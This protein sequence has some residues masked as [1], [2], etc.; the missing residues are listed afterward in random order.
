VSNLNPLHERAR[1][2]WSDDKGTKPLECY[3]KYDEFFRSR[4]PGFTPTSILEI[5]VHLG[6]STKIFAEVYREAK[7]VGIDIEKHEIDFSHHSN[8]LYLQ[9]DQGDARTLLSIIVEHFPQGVDLVIDDASH[10]GCLSKMT[11]DAVF[12][13]VRPGGIYIVEDWGTGYWDEWVDG[14]RYQEFT[15]VPRG[16]S[17]PKRMPSHDFGMVGFVK[18]LVDMT[19][20]PDIR[21]GWGAP[22][23]HTSSRIK[24]LQFTAGLCIAEKA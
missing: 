10:I 2:S 6:E 17:V 3:L 7:I 15:G 8:I 13:R 23:V 24:T 19:S 11:F 16:G 5:G 4:E 20:E 18:S 12:P 1:S 22:V 14:S 9:A 21:S